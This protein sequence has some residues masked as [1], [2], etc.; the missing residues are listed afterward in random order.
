MVPWDGQT[1]GMQITGLGLQPPGATAPWKQL[2][3][4]LMHLGGRVE[5]GEETGEW[6]DLFWTGAVTGS[7]DVT[8]W[9]GEPAA[10]FPGPGVF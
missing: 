4:P 3:M 5:E 2:L 9:S 7:R 1:V 6:A 8:T 10:A